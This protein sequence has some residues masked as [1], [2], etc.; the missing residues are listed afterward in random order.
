MHHLKRALL[1]CL[2]VAVATAFAS[3]AQA[4]SWEGQCLT[5]SGYYC[6]SPYS[7]GYGTTWRYTSGKYYG[8]GTIDDF[9]AG[10]CGSAG[11]ARYEYVSFNTTFVGGCWY[12]LP[13]NTAGYSRQIEYSG[14]SHTITTRVDDSR[15]HTNCRDASPV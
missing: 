6:N 8:G 9:R 3:A 1:A 15:N 14:A 11:C 5:P 2:V 10:M 13:S 4:A 7:S 12:N